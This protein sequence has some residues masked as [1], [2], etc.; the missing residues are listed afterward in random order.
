MFNLSAAAD[1][2]FTWQSIVMVAV[3]LAIV[4]AA[5]RVQK[6]RRSPATPLDADP[7]DWNIE[8]PK[9]I[10]LMYAEADKVRSMTAAT[11]DELRVRTSAALTILATTTA[12][13]TA[14]ATAATGT[15]HPSIANSPLQLTALSLFFVSA[16]CFLVVL[17]PL[18][19]WAFW[20]DVA[21]IAN[22]AEDEDGLDE[23]GIKLEVT[24]D[25]T[26]ALAGDTK[27]ITRM[28]WFFIGAIVAFI[29]EVIFW[30]VG[31]LL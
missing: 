31:I 7:S 8:D 11:L 14:V 13:F 25:I 1:G 9:V 27:W 24:K 10:A 23:N 3:A 18:V 6:R 15:N 4:L 17:M 19:N 5:Y 12:I 29:G 16:V 20:P 30:I 26:F 28:Q 21:R 2:F 22:Y